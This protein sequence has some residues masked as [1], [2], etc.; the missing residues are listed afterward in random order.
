[1]EPNEREES[2]ER[3]SE[4]ILNTTQLINKSNKLSE[5]LKNYLDRIE[6]FKDEVEELI[7]CMDTQS[8]ELEELLEN[9]EDDLA[10]TCAQCGEQVK[11][12]EIY[13]VST[14]KRKKISLCKNCFYEK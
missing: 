3:L 11:P 9:I 8:E 1:M 6:K 7:S 14:P 4:I 5:A 2:K 10:V 12:N 13:Q